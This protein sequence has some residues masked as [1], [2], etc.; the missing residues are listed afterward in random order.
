M[1]VVRADTNILL[2]RERII[3]K[4]I[5]QH[6]EVFPLRKFVSDTDIIVEVGKMLI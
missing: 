3:V 1:Q 2:V 4:G 5:M 6:L